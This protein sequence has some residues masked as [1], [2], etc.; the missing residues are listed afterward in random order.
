MSNELPDNDDLLEPF[1]ARFHVTKIDPL[2]REKQLSRNQLHFTLPPRTDSFPSLNIFLYDSRSN[3]SSHLARSK[4]TMSYLP[5]SESNS[6]FD[7]DPTKIKKKIA[8]FHSPPI[9]EKTMN[10]ILEHKNVILYDNLSLQHLILVSSIL[11]ADDLARALII[12]PS[13]SY[14]QW[15]R[16][17]LIESNTICPENRDSIKKTL[18]NLRSEKTKV[19]ICQSYR[20]P[21][22][23]FASFSIC[24]VIKGEQIE[25]Q[26]IHLARFKIP[27]VLQVSQGYSISPYCLPNFSSYSIIRDT[28]IQY[29]I[30]EIFDISHI[31][32]ITSKDILSYINSDLQTAIIVP[33]KKDLDEICHNPII[34]YIS[35][36]QIKG[37]IVA[38]TIS[39]FFQPL[40]FQHYI[41]VGFPP[42]LGCY[43]SISST[44]IDENDE[45][46][47]RPRITILEKLSVA[48]FLQ[49]HSHT[50][51]LDAFSI[52]TVTNSIITLGKGKNT[53]IKDIAAESDI[54][55]T[56]D[57]LASLTNILVSQGIIQ[58]TS[59]AQDLAFAKVNRMNETM[60]S[61]PVI[62]VLL[63]SYENKRGDIEFSLCKIA[64]EANV[65]VEDALEVIE[66]CCE[67][68]CLSFHFNVDANTR[69][70]YF[71]NIN[72]TPIFI[73]Q[74]PPEKIDEFENNIVKAMAQFEA[75]NSRQFDLLFD[76][77]H[78]DEFR[79]S[80]CK[81]PNLPQFTGIPHED[82]N[83]DEVVRLLKA[84]TREKLTPR[85]VAY[86]LLGINHQTTTLSQWSKTNFWGSMENCRFEDV[87]KAF[88][89]ILKKNPEL[90][91][92]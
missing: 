80:L 16:S 38:G 50:K 43:L 32:T 33:T 59:I 69:G 64:N 75:D 37:R 84:N 66:K 49:A 34:R 21:S 5:F 25:N 58:P 22:L 28:N 26:L 92:I 62:N 53:T 8:S 46:F 42:S 11:Q 51:G 86:I 19:L 1:H 29:T 78:N 41:F 2:L 13:S 7:I 4:S 57:E 15:V 88:T 48:Q 65:S 90:L 6:L 24:L 72:S 56:S 60:R 79:N 81:L 45:T 71:N 27:I 70:D 12:V 14:A 44:V 36:K 54:Q 74:K 20:L 9:I 3:D 73:I 39:I 31:C 89:D 30:P 83:K 10:S 35:G 23:P 63:K 85:K 82:V 55:I 17:H 91:D 68:G 67:D 40:I 76:A 77:I 18:S 87:L 47:T 61:N 52:R